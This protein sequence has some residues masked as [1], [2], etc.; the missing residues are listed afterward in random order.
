MGLVTV[1]GPKVPASAPPTDIPAPK[2]ALVTP[3][4]KFVPNAVIVTEM[5]SPAWPDDGFRAMIVPDGSMTNAEVLP[6]EKATPVDVVPATESWYVVGIETAR[7][8]GT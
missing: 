8:V 4:M 6:L 2:F 5:C 7:D 1:T 3:W